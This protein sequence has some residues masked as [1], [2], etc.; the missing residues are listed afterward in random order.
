MGFHAHVLQDNFVASQQRTVR[1]QCWETI[2][3]VTDRQA[4]DQMSCS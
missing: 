3:R 2:E 4:D 1:R